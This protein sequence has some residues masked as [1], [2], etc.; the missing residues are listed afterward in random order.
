MFYFLAKDK[1]H[2]WTYI[3]IYMERNKTFIHTHF[4]FLNYKVAKFSKII[5]YC[6]KHLPSITSF[7]SQNFLGKKSTIETLYPT[8]SVGLQG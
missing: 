6:L 2:V 8:S 1:Q 4:Y 5:F 7:Y 3:Y